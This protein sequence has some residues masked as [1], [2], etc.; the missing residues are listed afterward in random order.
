[1]RGG[2]ERGGRGFENQGD[3]ARGWNLTE[4]EDGLFIVAD[5]GNLSRRAPVVLLCGGNTL[6][7]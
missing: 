4:V 7:I 1:M 3:C 6:D 5:E 2:R